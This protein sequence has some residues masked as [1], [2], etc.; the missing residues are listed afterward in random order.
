MALAYWKD[1]VNCMSSA[2][3]ACERTKKAQLFP[4]LLEETECLQ[5]LVLGMAGQD[6]IRDL[7]DIRFP[8]TARKS[9]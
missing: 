2:H 6:E 9:L 7:G 4:G 5:S 8:H 1:K 3:T